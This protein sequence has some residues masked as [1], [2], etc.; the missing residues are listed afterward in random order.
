T[1]S[2]WRGAAVLTLVLGT[3]G[4][5]LRAELAVL[6]DHATTTQPLA[7][8]PSAE[9]RDLVD[10]IVQNT[11]TDARLLWEDCHGVA[12]GSSWTALLPVW[13]GRAFLGGLDTGSALEHAQAGLI[14]R[15]LAGQPVADWSDTDLATYCQRYNLGW[16]ICRSPAAVAR[17]EQWCHSGGAEPTA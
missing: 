15:H 9:Q 8:G 12:S 14:D 5:L 11:D 10:T 2:V 4:W 13:T 3:A 7:F 16:V 1:G 6:A 17:F